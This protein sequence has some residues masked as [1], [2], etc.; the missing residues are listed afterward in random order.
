M[1]SAVLITGGHRLSDYL[2]SAEIYL[3]SVNTSCSLPE[4]PDGRGAHT[5]DGPWAC[6][7]GEDSS[8]ETTCDKFSEGIWTRQSLSLMKMRKEHVSWATASGVYLI[9]GLGGHY[10]GSGKTSEMV[11]EGGT[12]ENGFHLDYNTQ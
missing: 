11:K 7:G 12:V 8:T 3:P 6:G 5:Q 9:G 10:T 1:S 2:W 4:L